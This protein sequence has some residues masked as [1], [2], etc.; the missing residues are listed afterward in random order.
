MGGASDATTTTS[1]DP[2]GQAAGGSGGQ[3]AAATSATVPSDV[4]AVGQENLPKTGGGLATKL[5]LAGIA[6]FLGGVAIR[7]GEPE[8]S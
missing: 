3:G 6:L 2:G 8:V 5:L 1:S 4:S 7:F